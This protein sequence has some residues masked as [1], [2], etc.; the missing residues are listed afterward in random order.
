[1]DPATVAERVAAHGPDGVRYL[2]PGKITGTEPSAIRRSLG[3][4]GLA[5]ARA[6]PGFDVIADL[7][8]GLTGPYEGQAAMAERAVVVVAPAWKSALAAR[9]LVALLEGKEITVVASKFQGQPDHPGLPAP[10]VRVP[11]DPAVAGAERKGLAPLDAVPASAAIGAIHELAELLV[12]EEVR[13]AET[14]KA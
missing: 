8:A 14:V 7:A 6:D 3:A 4:L 10:S 9:R 11:Y 5:V 13:D 2:S 12:R 1:V